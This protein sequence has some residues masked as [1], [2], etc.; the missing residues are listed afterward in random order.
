M[1]NQK[2]ETL[3]NLALETPEVER[4]KSEQLGVGFSEE[5][6]TWELIVKYNGDIGKLRSNVVFV[7]EL[8]AGYGRD[9]YL[10]GNGSGEKAS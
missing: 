10:S 2:L 3:L 4:Q 7:E 6:R 9:E 5:D 1:A 8:I